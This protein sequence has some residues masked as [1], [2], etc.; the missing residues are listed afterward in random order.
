MQSFFLLSRFPTARNRRLQR[1][2]LESKGE[3]ENV[4]ENQLR[5]TYCKT[6]VPLSPVSVSF[7]RAS[8]SLPRSLSPEDQNEVIIGLISTFFRLTCPPR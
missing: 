3:T 7:E 2:R 8:L 6:E 4:K 5:M 1:W